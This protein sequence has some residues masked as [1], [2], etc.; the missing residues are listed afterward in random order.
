MLSHN[1]KFVFNGIGCSNGKFSLQVKP[2]SKPYQASPRYIAYALQCPFKEELECLQQQEII[3]PIGITET[4]EWCNILY[5]CQNLM[6]KSDY[7]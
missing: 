5:L 4:A 2:D 1:S 3:T 7:V 6:G